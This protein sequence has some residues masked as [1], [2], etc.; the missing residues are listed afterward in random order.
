VADWYPAL[1]VIADH[2]P[3]AFWRMANGAVFWWT[4]SGRHELLADRF[5]EE[6][7]LYAEIESVT[8]YR[9]VRAGREVLGCDWPA[10]C[11]ELAGVLGVRVRSLEGVRAFP[12][13]PPTEALVL[14]ADAEPGAAPDPA[15]T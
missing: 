9:E 2:R 12:S 15:G 3:V 1:A 14:E 8:V 10:V 5:A 4:P 13:S 11:E 7:F 6:P